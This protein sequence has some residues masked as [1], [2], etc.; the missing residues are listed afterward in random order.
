MRPGAP[1]HHPRPRW[2]PAPALTGVEQ[3]FISETPAQGAAACG[4]TRAAL[5]ERAE[6]VGGAAPPAARPR[7]PPGLGVQEGGGSPEKRDP[8]PR[9]PPGP[10]VSK[11]SGPPHCPCLSLTFRGRRAAS[12]NAGGGRFSRSARTRTLSTAGRAQ[13]THQGPEPLARSLARSHARAGPAPQR[14]R[15]HAIRGPQPYTLARAR[16][17]DPRGHLAVPSPWY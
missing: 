13:T 8:G 2:A 16:A 12:S 14:A 6:G 10:G 15:P 11:A 4:A 5:P 9:P 1:P 17:L 7:C 3:M